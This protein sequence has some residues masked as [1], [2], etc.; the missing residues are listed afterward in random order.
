MT[1]YDRLMEELRELPVVVIVCHPEKV[2]EFS[3]LKHRF[4]HY[5]IRV[6]GSFAIDDEREVIV[7]D[8]SKVFPYGKEEIFASVNL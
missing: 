3:K 7:Y 8:K 1:L 6:Q 5:N 2:E 4:G